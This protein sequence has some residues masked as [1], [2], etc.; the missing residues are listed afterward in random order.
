MKHAQRLFLAAALLGPATAAWA[1]HTYA[2]YDQTRKLTVEGT[3][4][5]LEWTNPHIWVWVEVADGG[6]VQTYGFESNAPS[7]L[8]RFFGW[9]K[10]ALTPGDKVTVD[11]SPL[12]SGRNGGALRTITF[13]DGRVL[14]TPR[15]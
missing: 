2:M 11:Y 8:T 13:G 7:E 15:S 12:K 4:T 9:T 1:H 3:V 6:G 14:L 10:R 5:V